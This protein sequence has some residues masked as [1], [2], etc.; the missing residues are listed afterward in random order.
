MGKF[1]YEVDTL[2]S[3]DLKNKHPATFMDEGV[4]HLL[5]KMLVSKLIISMV[6][7]NAITLFPIL[8]SYLIIQ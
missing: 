4:R 5:K 2:K 1:R 8:V 7:K 6:H 3:F